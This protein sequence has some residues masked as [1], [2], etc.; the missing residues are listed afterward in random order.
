[1]PASRTCHSGR[2]AGPSCWSCRRDV[3]SSPLRVLPF[4]A[5]RTWCMPWPRRASRGVR[6]M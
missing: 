4:T 1:L 5:A 3:W 2:L 6:P